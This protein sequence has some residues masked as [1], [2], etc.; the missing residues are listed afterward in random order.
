MI[1]KL[2]WRYIY[3]VYLINMITESVL[4]HILIIQNP[5]VRLLQSQGEI[6]LTCLHGSCTCYVNIIFSDVETSNWHKTTS[7]FKVCKQ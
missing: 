4:K 2:N 3:N 7:D 6:T 1:K 5:V